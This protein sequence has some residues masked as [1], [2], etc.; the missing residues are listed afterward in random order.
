MAAEEDESKSPSKSL[1]ISFIKSSLHWKFSI[2]QNNW[3]FIIGDI[4]FNSDYEEELYN[5]CTGGDNQLVYMLQNKEDKKIT[6]QMMQI[7][8][9][10]S[11]CANKINAVRTITQLVFK[12]TQE[13][14]SIEC[15]DNERKINQWHDEY[16]SFDMLKYLCTDIM[17]RPKLVF[18]FRSQYMDIECIKWM[19]DNYADDSIT[20]P[21]HELHMH[22]A[23]Y[24]CS[25]EKV[26]WL[27][28]KYPETDIHCEEDRS[29]RKAFK[30]GHIMVL[31]VLITFA[32]MNGTRIDMTT[33][34]WEKNHRSI[35]SFLEQIDTYIPKEWKV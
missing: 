6:I 16:R 2:N 14:Y 21:S 23:T 33:R 35:P 26:L 17:F 28:K 1:D 8:Y 10:L 24:Q 5:A 3:W 22:I 30:Y 27:L 31:G 13:T 9:S 12:E 20:D 34:K 25:V 4:K 32:Q 18:V 7:L 19:D 15:G 29:F 11:L